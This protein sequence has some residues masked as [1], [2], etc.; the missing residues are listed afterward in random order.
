MPEPAVTATPVRAKPGPPPGQAGA[1][2]T[3]LFPPVGAESV[4]ISLDGRPVTAKRGEL[5]IAVAERTGI[6]IPRFCYHPRLKAVGM[7]R[8]CLVEVKGPR[9]FTLSPACYVPAEDGLEVVT[10]SAKVKKAQD[11]VLEFLLINHPLDCPVC[12]RGGE[13]PLQ[14][15]TMAYGP[16]ETRFV[17]E[18]R[19]WDKPIPISPLILLD[20]ERCIQCARCTRFAEEVAGDAGIDFFS[21]TDAVEVATYPGQPFTSNFSGNVVQICPVG[22]LLASPYRFR[23]RP[24]DLE[25]VETTCTLCAVGCRMAAQS[26]ADRVVRFL[27]VDSDPVNWG[28]LCDK[29][30]FGFQAIES[31]RRLVHPLVRRGG[32]LRDASWGQALAEVASRVRNV[33]GERIGVIGGARLANEDAYAWAKFARTVLSTDNIDAQMGD[34]L[35]ADVVASLPRAT[36]DQVCDAALIV[37]LAP[38]IKEELPI[39]Y[40][41]LRHAAVDKAVPIIEV[42]PAV[43]G[44]S[45]YAALSLRYRPGEAAALVRALCSPVPVTEDV[46]GV[47]AEDAEG[48]RQAILGAS[49]GMGGKEAFPSP[50]A[51]PRLGVVIGRPSLAEPSTGPAEAALTLAAL[52]G[53]AFLPALRRANVHGAID[54]GLAPG[55]LPGRTALDSGR[56]WYEQHWGVPLPARPGLGTLGML[57]RARAGDVDVLFLVGADPATDCPDRALAAQALEAVPFVAAVDAF[58]TPS[59]ARADIVLP[60][61]IFTERRGSFTNLEGRITW[62]GQK[63]TPPGTARPDWL[64]VAELASRLG[65]DLGASNLDQ[66]W[67]EIERVS[68][69]H[70]GV[71]SALLTSRQGR[72]GVVVPLGLEAGRGQLAEVPPPLDP[73]AD[74]GIAQ[75]EVTPA[76][77]AALAVVGAGVGRT[78]V[79]AAG[80]E[81]LEANGGAA[82]AGPAAPGQHPGTVVVAELAPGDGEAM[83]PRPLSPRPSAGASDPTPSPGSAPSSPVLRLV[84]RRPMWDGGTLLQAAPSLVALHPP[85]ALALHP[86][87]MSRLR[88]GPGAKARVTSNRSTIAVPVVGD[89]AVAPGT[90]LLPFNLPEGGGGALVDA[91]LPW[92]EVTVEPLDVP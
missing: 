36:I 21:R 74:P 43:T 41:R 92:T 18:K 9:G 60:A 66:L 62:L 12:D 28:W 49:T 14:D 73:M 67:A 59:L 37:T 78:N 31:P 91:S 50:G 81:G 88:I 85:L 1:T 70:A 7:C 69:L 40:L 6:Y 17:E 71:S 34:G 13:C 72:N 5:L 44:L 32:E 8:M 57:E 65:S 42:S 89:T 39:L 86:D 79:L 55:L 19:H 24:W 29:G 56:A 82:A 27:G 22:A 61:A 53:T 63:V 52:P 25:Q 64:I 11:G 4:T 87:D 80:P 46:A 90:A 3:A 10:A 54:L 51:P 30:R 23:A 20:R 58:V 26:S 48:A 45:R 38:D 68:P 77:S 2:G 47:R 16:G 76:P 75:A 33:A 84:T 83:A 15:Q 35:P